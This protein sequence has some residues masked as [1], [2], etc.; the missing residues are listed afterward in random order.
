MSYGQPSLITNPNAALFAAV[1]ALQQVTGECS[2]VTR[3]RR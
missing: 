3:F 2:A 1:E